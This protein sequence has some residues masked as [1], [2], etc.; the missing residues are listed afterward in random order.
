MA[1]VSSLPVAK[2]IARR[3]SLVD[4]CSGS[5]NHRVGSF[6]NRPDTASG[7]IVVHG[8]EIARHA[9]PTLQ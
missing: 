7:E 1:L 9:G 2:L 6:L 3:V 5:L 4:C 8:A